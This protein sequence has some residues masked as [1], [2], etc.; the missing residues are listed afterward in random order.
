MKVTITGATGRVGAALVAGLRA[1]GDEVTV[2]SRSGQRALDRLPAGVEAV[3]WG[4]PKAGPAPVEALIGRD[5]V[6]H[7][8][9]ED[10]G[11]RWTEEVKREIRASRELGT[12]NLVE[13]LAAAQ[14]RPGLLISASAAGYYG[15]RGDERVDEAQGP[16]YDFLAQ[17]CVAWEREA[18]RAQDHGVRVVT[19][20]TGIVLD[21]AGGALAQMLTPFR[22][23]VGGPIA[24]GDQ[25]MPWIHLEDIVGIYLAALDSTT[26]SGAINASAPEPVTNGAFSKAL[27]K[28]IHRPALVPV[29]GFAIKALYGEMA[30]LVTEG[31]RMV[32]GRAPELGYAFVHP[33][34]DE[35]LRDTLG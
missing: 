20:R 21:K 15:P 28:A 3:A 34:L 13:G 14:P 26:F 6:V 31:V 4:D 1:R 11:R 9:G 16:G 5:A 35:A 22:L 8:A 32:P 12:R 7:L 10:V 18:R 19:V 33:D 24:G 25:Y 30:Q 17:V 2:L 29:P 23:G 27:G